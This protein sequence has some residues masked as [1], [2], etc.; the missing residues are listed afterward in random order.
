MSLLFVVVVI[1][2]IAGA[3][4]F[5]SGRWGSVAGLE[6]DRRP[7][8]DDARQFD[9]VLRGYRMDEVDARIAALEKENADL[10]GRAPGDGR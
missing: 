6:R 4:L 10:R 8:M 7:D 3:F 2:I 9:V 5:A 1:L